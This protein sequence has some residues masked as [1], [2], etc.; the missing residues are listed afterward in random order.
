[1]IITV[2]IPLTNELI[3]GVRDTHLKYTVDLLNKEERIASG[4]Q[5]E[6]KINENF[7]TFNQ[8]KTLLENT[9]TEMIRQ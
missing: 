7:M 8:R 3:R 9:I 6:E 1:M 5:E 4:E 2:N